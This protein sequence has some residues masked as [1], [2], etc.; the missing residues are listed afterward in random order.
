MFLPLRL[1]LS[2]NYWY[3]DEYIYILS[4]FV[5]SL[6][7]YFCNYYFNMLGT[8]IALITR[9]LYLRVN[10]DWLGIVTALLLWRGIELI[11]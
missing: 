2:V 9:T 7:Q 5:W 10:L 1:S 3:N 8:Y 11:Q 4:I 6:L